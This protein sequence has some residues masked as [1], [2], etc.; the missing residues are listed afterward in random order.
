M[1]EILLESSYTYIPYDH[2]LQ[3]YENK[4]II[5]HIVGEEVQCVIGEKG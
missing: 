1:F 4:W 3:I 5:N 2:F